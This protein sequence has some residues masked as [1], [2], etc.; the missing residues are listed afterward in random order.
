MSRC[1]NLHLIPFLNKSW[2]TVEDV[3]TNLSFLQFFQISPPQLYICFTQCMSESVRQTEQLGS[4][5]IS[6]LWRRKKKKNHHAA[7]QKP[8]TVYSHSPVHCTVTAPHSVQPQPYT[9]YSHYPVHLECTTKT[10][11]TYFPNLTCPCCRSLSDRVL[12][13]Q[14]H[15]WHRGKKAAGRN[16]WIH[17]EQGQLCG[18]F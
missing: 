16:I 4:L 12:W 2:L 3:Q 13:C 8:C 11:L 14:G 7:Q 6:D 18:S 15:S 1:C 9:V 10:L 17:L 5:A